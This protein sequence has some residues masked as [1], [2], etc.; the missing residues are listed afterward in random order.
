MKILAPYTVCKVSKY[1]V[2]SSPH[3]PVLSPNTGKFGPERSP[4]LGTFHAVIDLKC[5]Q[6]SAFGNCSLA[7]GVLIM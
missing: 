4:Y 7:A 5:N 6:Y 2:F 1:G 3:F